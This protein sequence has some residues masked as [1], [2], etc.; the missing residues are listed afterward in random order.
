MIKFGWILG[1]VVICF[2]S[3]G[4]TIIE[5]TGTPIRGIWKK[6]KSPYIINQISW[7]YYTI[8]NVTIEPGVTVKCYSLNFGKCDTFNACGTSEEPIAF[9]LGT[10]GTFGEFTI[11]HSKFLHF[12]NVQFKNNLSGLNFESDTLVH[13]ENMELPVTTEIQIKN[14]IDA[15]FDSVSIKTPNS[16]LCPQ[17][18]FLKLRGCNFN[19]VYFNILYTPL[20]ISNSILTNNVESYFFQFVGQST[21]LYLKNNYISSSKSSK[22]F[23]I[24]RANHFTMSGCTYS[25]N[26]VGIEIQQCDSVVIQGNM[27]EHNAEGFRIYETKHLILNNN[28]ISHNNSAGVRFLS[29]IGTIVVNNNFIAN[30][31][32]WNP[33]SDERQNGAGICSS[34]INDP[35]NDSLTLTGNIIVNN[36]AFRYGGAICINAKY[37]KLA[38]NTIANNFSKLGIGVVIS[39]PASFYNNIIFG[40]KSGLTKNQITFCNKSAEGSSIKNCLIQNGL[41]G[42]VYSDSNVYFDTTNTLHPF[43]GTSNLIS[44][45]SPVFINPSPSADSSC[46]GT[47]YDWRLSQSSPCIDKG[48]NL[49]YDLS[50]PSTDYWGNNR[51]FN[52]IIDIGANEYNSPTGTQQTVFK[53][54]FFP[55]TKPRCFDLLGRNVVKSIG[56]T[57]IVI[58]KTKSLFV[59]GIKR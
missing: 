26:N 24:L 25:N 12:K 21:P 9:E 50:F 29:G 8:K 31:I 2:S 4:D 20:E 28:K 16:T 5:F 53:S 44:S 59:K 27:I 57:N 17:N 43:N 33:N 51:I 3:F 52:N 22:I 14:T 55:V 32:A 1:V 11:S 49:F 37:I 38:N 15:V 40:N 36:Y 6:E 54:N 42:I 56:S 45:E 35:N 34:S 47:A 10:G 58:T 19:N 18:S 46:D 48:S 7:P 41:D 30:N 23:M 39:S 13:F